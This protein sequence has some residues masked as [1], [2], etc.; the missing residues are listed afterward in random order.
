M[1]GF[2]WQHLTDDVI[3][4]FDQFTAAVDLEEIAAVG[5]YTTGTLA[6]LSMWLRFEEMKLDRQLPPELRTR[7]TQRR[8]EAVN[9]RRAENR[10]WAS[11]AERM[12]AQRARIK[13]EQGGK[14]RRYRVQPAPTRQ[15]LA[16]RNCRARKAQVIAP[17]VVSG[18]QVNGR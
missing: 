3:G 10:R 12:R 7:L 8:H 14:Q 1:R 13:A 15:A 4:E 17:G 11:D 2:L 16:Q 5:G 18:A 6:G 9:E